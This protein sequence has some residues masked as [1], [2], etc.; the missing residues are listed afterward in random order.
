[1]H[2]LSNLITYQQNSF[3]AKAF[4]LGVTHL[5]FIAFV[6]SWVRHNMIHLGPFYT[7]I[8]D[9]D[10]TVL[11]DQTELYY[12]NLEYLTNMSYTIC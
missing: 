5:I 7:G 4:L 3:C 1:M 2:Q 10:S 12:Q 6:S 9:H 8:G 11:S